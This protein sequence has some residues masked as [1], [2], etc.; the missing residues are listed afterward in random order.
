MK[1]QKKNARGALVPF[2]IAVVVAVLGTAALV[3]TEFAARDEIA[4]GNG[5]S[6]IT[7]AAADRAGATVL[8][9]VDNLV[10]NQTRSSLF[11]ILR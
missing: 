4:S 10:A 5:V 7:A 1:I 3:V 8:P 11:R 9:T 6:T 2:V